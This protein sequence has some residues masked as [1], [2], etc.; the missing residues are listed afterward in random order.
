MPSSCIV[1]PTRWP[2]FFLLHFG[3]FSI[4]ERKDENMDL[5]E[6]EFIISIYRQAHFKEV[7]NQF[8]VL[9][10]SRITVVSTA[11]CAP[12]TTNLPWSACSWQLWIYQTRNWTV[13]STF[14]NKKPFSSLIPLSPV[15]WLCSSTGEG[16]CEHQ[17]ARQILCSQ[18]TDLSSLVAD[19]NLWA[20]L[21][22]WDEN[23]FEDLFRGGNSN[24]TP[25]SC[26]SQ[27]C[28]IIPKH[29]PNHSLSSSPL[30]CTCRPL[31]GCASLG[32]PWPYRVWV[33]VLGNLG[34]WE[35]SQSHAVTILFWVGSDQ[36]QVLG[37]S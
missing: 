30:V 3:Y 15:L 12:N 17:A 16:L 4:V 6:N 23:N 28:D 27:M 1:H 14:R 36:E 37:R 29:N 25:S 7:R 31:H 35:R 18:S 26:F 24:L 32:A 9:M 11:H 33:V 8:F 13:N 21:A 19:S 34:S 20:I 5:M 22:L 10:S 2:V